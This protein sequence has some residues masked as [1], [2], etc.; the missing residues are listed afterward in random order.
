MVYEAIASGEEA[1]LRDMAVSGIA[2]LTAAMP[3]AHVGTHV[4]GVIRRLAEGT[5][6][7]QRASACGILHHVFPLLSAEQQVEVLGFVQK[8]TVDSA[9]MVRRAVAKEMAVLIPVLSQQAVAECIH[10]LFLELGRDEQDSVRMLAMEL[11]VPIAKMVPASSLSTAILPVVQAGAKDAAWRVRYVIAKNFTDIQAVLG[12]EL[13]QAHL[14]STFVE[15]VSDSEA[16]VRTAACLNLGTFCQGLPAEIQ[17]DVLLQA[18]LPQLQLRVVDDREEVRSALGS[19]VMGLSSLLGKDNTITYLLP[20]FLQLLKDEF[21][22]VRLKIISNLDEVNKVIGI[23][24]LSQA[25]Q[26]AINELAQHDSWRVRKAIIEH[27]PLVSKQLG[28]EFFDQEL[29]ALCLE[30]LND[31]VHSVRAAAVANVR[32]I[33]ETFGIEWA[34]SSILPRVLEKAQKSTTYT[35]R[36]VSVFTINNI[37]EICPTD[38]IVIFLVPVLCNSM[39]TDK[40]ANIRFNVAKTLEKLLPLVDATTYRAQIKDVLDTMAQDT[41][42]DVSYFAKRALVVAGMLKYS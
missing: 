30:W 20:L 38:V 34:K 42:A 27:I 32:N 23:G 7:A 16:E 3:Q 33:I 18:V 13:T 14:I 12:V 36:I 9:A 37:I 29:C 21:S 11:C 4:L 39:C 10:P 5:W 40:V 2:S 8:L 19:V 24:Q 22:E 26:P 35:A 41:D 6:Y 1:A 25:L 28:V 15:L 31:K 17:S